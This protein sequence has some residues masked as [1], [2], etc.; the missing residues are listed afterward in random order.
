MI[1]LSDFG[2]NFSCTLI[3]IL[4]VGIQNHLQNVLQNYR[5]ID[6]FCFHFILHFICFTPINLA[7]I[8]IEIV[9]FMILKKIKVIIVTAIVNTMELKI[10]IIR[11][12]N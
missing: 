3:I 6:I 7:I 5:A 9:E 11:N 2:M 1:L 10:T 4:K 8:Y 12:F